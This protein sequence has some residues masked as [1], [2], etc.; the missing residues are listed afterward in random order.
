MLWVEKDLAAV[1][2]AVF[3]HW[4]ARKMELNH[5]YLFASSVRM[6]Y[7]ELVAII[8]KGEHMNLVPS[9]LLT[10]SSDRKAHEI[11]TP[12]DFGKRRT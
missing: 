3:D 1:C 5:Q 6:S 11:H 9:L 7:N 8:E 2:K 12:R 4:Y 10:V